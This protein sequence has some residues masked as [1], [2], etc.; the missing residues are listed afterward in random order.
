MNR[1]LPLAALILLVIATA[2]GNTI[3]SPYDTKAYSFPS[4]LLF[5]VS[6]KTN[7][8]IY[9]LFVGASGNKE[10]LGV[11]LFYKAGT[12]VGF[13]N[14]DT[15]WTLVFEGYNSALNLTSAITLNSPVRIGVGEKAAFR[16]VAFDN[17]FVA[18]I[19]Q[20]PD[21][22]WVANDDVE[23]LG[24]AEVFGST[25]RARRLWGIIAYSF[26]TPDPEPTPTPTPEPTPTPTPEPA[27]TLTVFGRSKITTRRNSVVFQGSAPPPAVWA[28]LAWVRR[29]IGGRKHFVTRYVPV[30]A[31][32]IWKASIKPGKRR[33]SVR[34]LS[35]NSE[36]GTS[37]I[38][39]VRVKPS[40]RKRR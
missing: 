15:A 30:D 37:A 33:T 10:Y 17:T 24:G 26:F 11:R 18:S 31:N 40:Q 5:D 8:E 20:S 13:E 3:Y 6:A 25:I 21:S 4:N 9:A 34:I 1:R 36:G 29:E 38:A 16:L 35:L 12:Y 23:L 7:V 14:D 39:T 27:P 28:V 22:F 19:I 2:V 32:G